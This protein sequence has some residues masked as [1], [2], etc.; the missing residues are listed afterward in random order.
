MTGTGQ[1]LLLLFLL[2]ASAFCALS[3]TGLVALSRIRLRHLVDQG[4]RN[5]RGLQELTKRLDQ[6]ITSIVVANNFINTAI[7]SIGAALCIGW[8]GPQWGIPVATV[9][10]GSVILLFGEIT[11]KVFAIRYP[12]RVSLAITPGMKVLLKVLGPVSRFFSALSSFLLHLMGV[13][14]GSRSPLV[15]EEEIKL[16]IQLGKEE[17]VLGEHERTLLHRVFEF[18]DQKVKDVMVPV[19]QMVAVPEQAGH[20]EILRVLTEEGHS[21]IPVY[22][23]SPEEIVGILYAQELLHVWREKDLIVLADLLHPA[24]K[25]QPD[26]S[27]SEL[28]R[29]LQKRRIQ[30]AIVTDAQGKTV[31]L[32]TLEDMIEEIV[33]EIEGD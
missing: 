18:G 17:G 33:G 15:T 10:M 8:L 4:V 3:E 7:S 27:V 14:V 1:I 2:A 12:A 25:V 20:E 32:V 13:E 23:G 24:Y 16:M 31:G 21:R 6:V 5:A 19:G 29:E 22:R 11:P 28:L 30:I 9:L 26:R